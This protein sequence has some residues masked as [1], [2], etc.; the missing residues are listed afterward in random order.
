MMSILILNHREISMNHG[1][2]QAHTK[3]L[4]ML[5][6]TIVDVS[7]SAGG[8]TKEKTANAILFLPALTNPAKLRDR[9]YVM[10]ST[11]RHVKKAC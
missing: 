2:C 9:R 6:M 3:Y 5:I 7:T 4:T 11:H 8:E 10:K 1:Q